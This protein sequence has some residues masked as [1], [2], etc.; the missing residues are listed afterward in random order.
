M[1]ST[2]AT[3]PIVGFAEQTYA[4]RGFGIFV[5]IMLLVQVIWV[6]RGWPLKG[7]PL[8]GPLLNLVGSILFV[9]LHIPRYTLPFGT[10]RA[11][12]CALCGYAW[13]PYLITES[14]VFTQRSV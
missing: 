7:H 2:I 14:V 3:E 9:L 6:I 13:T 10:L 4:S 11:D 12:V 5:C 8:L 1:N